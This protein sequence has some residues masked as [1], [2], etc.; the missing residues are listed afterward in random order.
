MC[1]RHKSK[2]LDLLRRVM[3]LGIGRNVS[4]SF[5]PSQCLEIVRELE[6]RLPRKKRKQSVFV[7]HT[8]N[9]LR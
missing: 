3:G 4:V 2:G 8:P 7:K 1:K 6:E 9:N 5:T